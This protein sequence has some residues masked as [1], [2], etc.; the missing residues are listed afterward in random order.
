MKNTEDCKLLVNE[1]IDMNVHH[2]EIV[3]KIGRYVAE[4]GGNEQLMNALQNY[5]EKLDAEAD[6][7]RSLYVVVENLIADDWLNRAKHK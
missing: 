2:R 5:L 3:R 7:V 1:L 4:D 6:A